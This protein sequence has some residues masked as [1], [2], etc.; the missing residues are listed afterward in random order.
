MSFES[1]LKYFCADQ[2]RHLNDYELLQSPQLHLKAQPEN[3][4]RN[5]EYLCVSAH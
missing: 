3:L 1:M 4:L 5:F 2:K